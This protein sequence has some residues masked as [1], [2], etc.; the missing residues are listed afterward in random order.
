VVL[1]GTL[2]RWSET[3]EIFRSGPRELPRA[4]ATR[5]FDDSETWKLAKDTTV[6]SQ[7]AT[8]VSVYRRR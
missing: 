7:V 2:L 6:W 4:A 3:A 1:R 5:F 8:R